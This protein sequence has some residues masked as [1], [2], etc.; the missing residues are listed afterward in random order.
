MYQQDHVNQQLPTLDWLNSST[1]YKG[2]YH[3]IAFYEG[4][5]EILCF[6]IT[7]EIF[8]NMK[9]PE[10]LHF[11]NGTLHSLL[12]LNECLSLVCYPCEGSLVDPTTNLMEIWIIEDYN[13]YESWIRKFTIIALPTYSPLAI[14][15][16][17]ILFFQSK[18]GY[19]VSY[20]LNTEEIKE[21]NIYMGV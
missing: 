18:T 21:L 19:F 9:I 1:A 11:S 16:D 4:E 12:L 13:V 6:N 5:D 8:L 20:D 17:Y 14:W 15:K 2:V 3:W 7:T 10:S